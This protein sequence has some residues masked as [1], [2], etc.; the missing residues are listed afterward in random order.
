MDDLF[1]RQTYGDKRRIARRASP[2]REPAQFVEFNYGPWDRLAE[3]A[4]FVP[5]VG[6]RPPGAQ[7][8]PRDMTKQEFEK[9]NLPGSRSEYTVLRRD[10]A[11]K[12][13]VVPYHVEYRGGRREEPRALLEQA[14]A[15]AEDAGL[16]RYLTAR[17]AALRTDDYRRQRSRMARHEEQ[18]HRPRD[19]AD[20]DLRGS[21]VRLQGVVRRRTCWSRT[22]SGASAS[23]RYAAMLP[24]LQRGLPVA[25]RVQGREAG[26]D[27]DLNA[28]DVL[29]YAGDC[30][31]GG[32]TIAINLPNDEKVQLE[33]GT[34]RL[35]LKNAMR[36][37]FDKI[38]VPI[39]D[40][41]IVPEQRSARDVRCLLRRHDV[42]RGGARPRHQEHD[43]RQGH[44][45]RRA[46]GT[47][48]LARGRQGRHPRPVHDHEAARKGRA[49]RIARGL[50]RHVPDRASSARCASAPRRRT[51]RR[52]WCAS[53]SSPIAAP[54]HATADGHYRVDVPAMRRAMDELSACIL[55]LQGDGDYAGVQ[56]L[57][58]RTRRHPAAAWQPTWRGSRVATFPSTSSSSRARPCSACS[59]AMTSRMAVVG[60]RDRR[61]S[62][63][64]RRLRGAAPA[65]CAR[66]CRPSGPSSSSITW[67][68]PSSARGRA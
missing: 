63:R 66:D 25:D 32:K 62:A 65:A 42:P 5:G 56:K 52:T 18:P 38:M 19:R 7:F 31:A 51:A 3:N 12:L 34:R 37:K 26:T 49:R 36:A 21:A 40:E 47:G 55:K 44:G 64:P 50:L 60:P 41:L 6:P 10:A 33:K 67:V 20:R 24:E 9:A 43:Q 35:Q 8:Y 13:K 30:N 45:A 53:I 22:W 1:W 2:I 27:S 14:A 54:S 23:S 28:Y 29:Y 15:L 11:G 57:A 39:A 68:R 4:P 58:D 16:K 61:P 48:E 46:E 17:A 59:D